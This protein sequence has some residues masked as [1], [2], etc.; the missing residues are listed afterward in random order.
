MMKTA[1]L[2]FDGPQ[3]CDGGGKGGVPPV[4]RSRRDSASQARNA[5]V[6][7]LDILKSCPPKRERLD[8]DSLMHPHSLDIE[9]V[10]AVLHG[11]PILARL[12]VF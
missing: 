10:T 9:V 1:E 5:T 2:G 6:H 3:P 7:L 4:Y 12:H 11:G 8:Q